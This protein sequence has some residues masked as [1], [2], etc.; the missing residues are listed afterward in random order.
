MSQ[1]TVTGAAAT[2]AT[3]NAT[4]TM[5]VETIIS[6]VSL[7]ANG[8]LAGFNTQVAGTIKTLDVDAD[9]KLAQLQVALDAAETGNPYV[10]QAIAGVHAVAKAA[11]LSLPSEDAV[12]AAIKASVDGLLGAVE[13]VPAS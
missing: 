6:A 4:E 5:I 2:P 7:A 3:P 8:R 12:F 13:T 1:S 11:G 10:A 9:A